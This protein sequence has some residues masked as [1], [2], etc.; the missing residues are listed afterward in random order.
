MSTRIWVDGVEGAGVPGDDPGLLLGL[1]VFDTHRTY[2]GVPFCLEAHLDRLLEGAARMDIAAPP[3][4]QVRAEVLAA[5][6]AHGLPDL[7]VRYTLTAGG[8][9]IVTTR[10]I[11][12]DEPSAP[13]TVARMDWEPPRFL[14]G[15]VKHGSRAAWELAARH[16]GVDQVILVDPDGFV[17]EANRSNVFAV[18][19]GVLVTPPLDDRFLA[20]VTRGVLLEVAR[21]NGIACEERPLPYEAPFEELY[22]SASIRELAPVVARDGRPGPG[23]GPVGARLRAAYRERAA[24]GVRG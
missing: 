16:L 19:D 12:P 11:D 1:T 14:P 20:G 13:L 15:A 4:E 22:L 24:R 9:R 5:I 3:R 8:R 10:P 21:A 18:I 7:C 6:E 23:G 2:D 17:L